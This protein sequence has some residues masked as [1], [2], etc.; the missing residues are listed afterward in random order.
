MFW[1]VARCFDDL[2]AAHQVP[3]H[4]SMHLSGT[5]L[6]HVPKHMPKNRLHEP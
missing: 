4:M 5:M 6:E 1:M 3:K 2:A